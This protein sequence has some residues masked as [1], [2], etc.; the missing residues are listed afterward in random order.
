MLESQSIL[1]RALFQKFLLIFKGDVV[2]S[3]YSKNQCRLQ[4]TATKCPNKSLFKQSDTVGG[5]K[6]VIE[7]KKNR[8]LLKHLLEE[9]FS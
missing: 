9:A 4:K 3:R 8:G 1:Y 2:Y 5:I 7:I 6:S